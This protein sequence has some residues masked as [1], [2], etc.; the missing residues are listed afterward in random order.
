MENT[1]YIIEDDFGNHVFKDKEFESF[2]D[3]WEFLYEQFPV[4]Y[5]D[6]GTQDDQEEEL[7][8]HY[9]VPKTDHY[10]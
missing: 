9:V 8:T 7:D 2:E 5:N 3:G 4:I 10:Q 6:D 1:M